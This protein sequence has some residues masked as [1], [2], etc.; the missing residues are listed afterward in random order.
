MESCIVPLAQWKNM[1]TQSKSSPSQ[2]N[3]SMGSSEVTATGWNKHT[4]EAQLWLHLYFWISQGPTHFGFQVTCQMYQLLSLAKQTNSSRC[5]HQNLLDS[6]VGQ[7]LLA[8][9]VWSR[10]MMNRVNWFMTSWMDFLSY[11]C[12]VLWYQLDVAWF[13]YV[14]KEAQ[15]LSQ[16]D[17]HSLWSAKLVQHMKQKIITEKYRGQNKNLSRACPRCVWMSGCVGPLCHQG[18]PKQTETMNSLW[19]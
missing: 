6:L 7:S 16:S 19:F 3:L 15:P 1:W 11:L 14:E 10:D 4:E 9:L 18:P 8:A 17:I 2:L 5:F 13:F 12:S